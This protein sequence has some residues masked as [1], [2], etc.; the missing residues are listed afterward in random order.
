MTVMWFQY[1]A[2]ALQINALP[3]VRGKDPASTGLLQAAAHGCLL[4]AAGRR[5]GCA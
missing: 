1:R 5:A 4:V 2:V 3:I